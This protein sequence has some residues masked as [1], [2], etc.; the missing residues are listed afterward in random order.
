MTVFVKNTSANTLNNA[1]ATITLPNGIEYVAGTVSGAIEQSIVNL[2][3]PVF[4]LSSLGPNAEQTF[5]VKVTATCA[6]IAPI[7]SG[8]LFTAKVKASYTG[9][10]DEVNSTNFKVETGLVVVVSASPTSVAGEIGDVIN[11]TI[12]L[13]NT[14]LGPISQ[15]NFTD[16]H[17]P[18]F[19]ATIIGGTMETNSPVFFTSKVGGSVFSQFGDGDNLFEFDEQITLTEKIT[20][21]DC[22]TPSFDNPSKIRIGWGCDAAQCQYDSTDLEV[23]ILPS[24]KNPNLI[25]TT[26]YGY[27]VDYCASIPSTNLVTIQNTGLVEAVNLQLDFRNFFLD[28][29]TGMDPNTFEYSLNNGATWIPLVLNLGS[30]ISIGSCELEYNNRS[31]VV[32][33]EVPAQSTVLMRYKF[34]TCFPDCS[35][36]LFPPAMFTFYQKPCPLGATVTDSIGFAID[37]NLIEIRQLTRLDIMECIVEGESYDFNFTAVSPRF[38]TDTTYMQARIILPKGMMWD[39][40]CVAQQTIEG[41]EPVYTSVEVD[42]ATGSTTYLLAFKLPFSSDS[43]NMPF[44][45]KFVCDAP[46]PCMATLGMLTQQGG[47]VTA[48]PVQCEDQCGLKTLTQASIAYTPDAGLGCGLTACHLFMLNV[49]A[50][51]MGG[52]GGAG[53]GI[54]AGILVDMSTYRINYGLEDTDDNRVADGTGLA[55]P[56]DI[57]LDRYMPGDTLRYDLKGVVIFGNPG[58][59]PIQINTESLAS[60]FG[61]LDGDQYQIAT[62]RTR[63]TNID[64]L[65]IIRAHL[66]VKRADGT[67][68]ECDAPL[69]D[70]KHQNYVDMEALNVQPPNIIDRFTTMYRAYALGLQTC[71]PD[72]QPLSPGDSLFFI[73]EY[74]FKQNY[75]PARAGGPPPALINF[76]N[77]VWNR[78]FAW[79]YPD[80][81]GWP[82]YM[83]QYSGYVQ[84]RSFPKQTIKPCETSLQTTP[85]GYGIRLARGNMFPNEVRQIA[86]VADFTYRIAP[87][88]TLLSALCDLTLQ[89]GVVWFDNEPI[90]WSNTGL[91]YMFDYA[92]TIFDLAIDEGWSLRTDFLFDESCVFRG[93]DTAQTTFNIRYPEAFPNETMVEFFR[94]DNTGFLDAA[95][96]LRADFQQTF[97]NMSS[98]NFDIEFVL[99]N[100]RPAEAPNAW[101]YIEPLNGTVTDLEI[102]RTQTGA[103][104]PGLANLFQLGTIPLLSQE[105]L[106][107]KGKNSNCNSLQLRLIIGWDC[108][109]VT[110]PFASSC[111]RDTVDLD[112]RLSSAV[113]ELDIKKQ[114]L[115]VPLCEPSDFFEFEIS[116]ANDG[117]GLGIQASV[118]LPEGLKV[119]PGSCQVQYPSP[120]GPWVNITDPL[121][122][123]GNVNLWLMAD[124]L[125]TLT[126]GLPGFITAPNN[127]F[128]IRF[129]TIA[130]CGFV[131]NA[132]PIY[133]VDGIQPC[134]T[135]TNSLRKP[136]TPIGL[137]GVGPAYGVDIALSPTN[138]G[139]LGCGDE[140][141]IAVQLLL[142]GTPAA[143][144]SVYIT[145][146]AGVSYVAGS[147]QATQNA[148]TG[149]PSLIGST[150]QIGLVP[151]LS[152]GS[153]V[154]FNIKLKYDGAAGC[155]DK[156][157]VAQ[158][159]QKIS[160]FCATLNQS[161]GVYI[162]TGEALLQLPSSN[163]DLKLS[164]FEPGTVSGGGGFTF[165]A[166]VENPGQ[167]TASSAVLEL[168]LDQNG[169]GKPDAGEQLL[170]TVN[171]NQ[172]IAPGSTATQT[173]TLNIP[174]ADLCKLLA[175]LPAEPN[176]AC[177][178]KYFPI[179]NLIVNQGTLARCAVEPVSFGVPNTP[180][181]T[182]LW[183]PTN[184][185]SCNNC[186]Q[187]TF[188]PNNTV[189]NGDFFT[190]VLLEQS[191][192]CT[193]EHRFE[194][195]FGEA[196]GINT[197][198]QTICKGDS[199]I[200]VASAGG[201]YQWTGPG[202]V[203]TAQQQTL[204][205]TSTTTYSVTVTLSA[206]CT[207]TDMV[208]VNVLEPTTINLPPVQICAGSTASIFGEPQT[209]SGQY[210]KTFPKANGC[211]STVCV[212]LTVAPVSGVSN[213]STCGGDSV[214][215]FQGQ[216]EITPGQYCKTFTNSAGC[217]STHCVTLSVTPDVTLPND[218]T[219]ISVVEGGSVTLPGPGGYANYT[220]IGPAPI[221]ELSCTDCQS[222]VAT[223][224]GETTYSV[225]VAN[226]G[227]CSD[228]ARYRVLVVPP[229]FEGVQLPNAFTPGN[230]GVNDELKAELVEGAFEKV[231]RLQVYNRWGQ[232]IYDSSTVPMW[233]GNVQGK[234]APVDVYIM[235]FDVECNGEVRRL[236]QREVT[237]LR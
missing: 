188:T 126:T 56:A 216:F 78:D 121:V 44:C 17:F 91:D 93:P 201:T 234:P 127:A 142:E 213:V 193:I 135:L 2:S 227:G 140:V 51:C 16:Q 128:R 115:E 80:S 63:L 220:W 15:L 60:D 186:S 90:P 134:G 176:C 55:K 10:S 192:G 130:E 123:Q 76:R 138:N 85:F 166:T 184:F 167:V 118:K 154:K 82:R 151:G 141:E 177:S 96:N 129:R 98:E 132:Q 103:S 214:E 163:P 109:P 36:V 101:I 11:R 21:T 122:L 3:V 146:P 73:Y 70:F 219:K 37:T 172:A 26:Q 218:T 97:L 74:Q 57:R 111:G 133:G 95:P 83:S 5:T 197:P 20:I 22:G 196:L 86:E 211:D 169:N 89:E 150:L 102:I 9:G 67:E 226:A 202:V 159:R 35:Q 6:L 215:V 225:V 33:P 28:G 92:N 45:L 117:N 114:P 168:W 148:P 58:D 65:M 174:L 139:A 208:T 171:Y 48:Y 179:E 155:I 34:F 110:N 175:V 178:D 54:P 99:K 72:N 203:P 206:G 32:I 77:V 195:R 71:S 136:H 30:P 8:Q 157:V 209:Q 105:P 183:Q 229:C 125:P 230:G 224:A 19:E 87:D 182:Y 40:S 153:V 144:D 43:I 232:R 180:G 107:I 100:T 124:I 4:A 165:T 64:S 210:C 190:F 160:G 46:L 231:V 66:R 31:V 158:T 75:A 23:T 24:T 108:D 18:G 119:V 191:G 205:P 161:C 79:T 235:I 145:L 81:I 147:Y 143:G 228:T 88:A 233:D 1:T 194:I 131:A 112:L 52:G 113:L 149:A 189:Q 13:R 217:D 94:R 156:F 27:P 116:N 221:G 164:L 39:S 14:R 162:S 106:R 237:L 84:T 170:Q 185:L 198:D 152:N 236:P 38:L 204:F 41:K 187:P 212:V 42:P 29:F 50:P 47:N 7:N 49:Q 59:F 222:P 223:P 68:Y 137:E 104:L 173:G 207:G 120:T 181:N 61:L 25:F 199:A 53:S 200:L 62:G 69:V 12:V